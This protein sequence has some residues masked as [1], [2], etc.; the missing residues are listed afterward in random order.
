MTGL[1]TTDSYD[2]VIVGGGTAASVIAN[3]LTEAAGV[4][5]LVLE[6]GG[7]E[8]PA[9]VQDPA[10]W[11]EVLLTDLDWAYMSEPQPGLDGRRVYS[12]SGRGLG[13]TSNVYHMMHTRGRPADYNAWAYAGAAGW[14]YE[15]VL[16]YLQKL[17]NQ[18]DDTNPTGGRSGPLEVVDAAETG[19]P[20]SQTFLEAC[21]EL[22][23][24]RVADLNAEAFGAG[25]HHVNIRDGRR[26]GVR[27]GY[28]EPALDRDNL[29]VTTGAMVTA[30]TFEGTRCAGVE[31]RRDGASLRARAEREVVVCA[32]AIQSPK[33]LMLSGIG[34]PVHL[35]EV[36]VPVRLDL[37]GVGENFHD[38]PLT[39]G[40]I[41]Y[42]DRPGADPRGQVT[43]VGLFWGSQPG[44]AVPDLEICLVHRAPFGDQF[45]ANVIK[46]VETGEPL[47][48]VAQ[49]VDP[50]VILALPG[51]VRP[52][53]RGWVRLAGS[54]PSAHPRISPN[55]FGERADLERMTQMVG[56]ARD[57]Y[58]SR[59]FTES[60]KLTELAPGPGVKAGRDLEEWVKQ[61]VGSYYHFAGSCRMGLD[62]MAVVDPRLRVHGVEGLRVADASVMP[63]VTSTNPHTTVVMIGERAADVIKQDQAG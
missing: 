23:Y 13:G 51:L 20:V 24:P 7:A 12:A 33:L 46:R 52:Y 58:A 39:I 59:A 2:Y 54:D 30:L 61:N 57:I 43:E 60:W 40:P 10:R 48:P 4:R 9:A 8:V 35:E 15:D 41:G 11:N 37:P 36:G 31:Y 53:S 63:A 49:L 56:M 22:G 26:C 50:K 29:T 27:A 14:G 5:V 19:N 34:D 18:V 47:A 28:L 55:Y 1:D 17:E 44:L 45:F 25:W 16:P 42:L 3:R 21:A 32:G 6:A 38:H 62:S